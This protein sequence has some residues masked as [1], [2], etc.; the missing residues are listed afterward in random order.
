M[1]I[2]GF[3]PSLPA[4][5]P[6][7]SSTSSI[8]SF[9]P[10]LSPVPC[11]AI[12]ITSSIDSFSSPAH[13]PAISITSSVDSLPH[14]SPPAPRAISITSTDNTLLPS[15]PPALHLATSIASAIDGPPLSSPSLSLHL[16]NPSMSLSDE[17]DET[18][19]T[20]DNDPCNGRTPECLATN[21]PRLDMI[22]PCVRYGDN[23]VI[24]YTVN[25]KPVTRWSWTGIGS[26]YILHGNEFVQ[27]YNKSLPK[28]Y[29]PL[30]RL[31]IDD[32][33]P[34]PLRKRLNRAL[35]VSMRPNNKPTGLARLMSTLAHMAAVFLSERS[36]T[37]L[38][39]TFSWMEPHHAFVFNPP[40]CPIGLSAPAAQQFHNMDYQPVESLDA[41]SFDERNVTAFSQYAPQ[42]KRS[43]DMEHEE[44]GNEGPAFLLHLYDLCSHSITLVYLHPLPFPNGS[45]SP[46]PL[47]PGHAIPLAPRRG[48]RAY[49]HMRATCPIKSQPPFPIRLCL[50]IHPA[51]SPARL[52]RLPWAPSRPFHPI[53]AP[54]QC[55]YHQSRYMHIVP[56]TAAQIRV[57]RM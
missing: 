49:Y 28:L 44:G 16:T 54:M 1:S 57:P 17:T 12:S 43:K 51:L 37:E 22:L 2:D 4:P 26:T 47:L 42:E 18:D 50:V 27:T 40:L 7:I 25:T 39:T 30:I 41:F 48:V 23:I 21:T 55:H 24:L 5:R 14:S 6:A 29:S 36:G 31:K 34:I 3:S 46:S 20:D 56:G 8:D 38:V 19:V 53:H 32:I 13:R 9:P 45:P 10:P 33:L 52:P 35:P 11:P 15:S